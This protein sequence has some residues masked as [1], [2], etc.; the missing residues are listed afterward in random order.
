MSRNYKIVGFDWLERTQLKPHP[1]AQ[2]P[3]SPDD[4]LA[5]KE[6]IEDGGLI[7]PLLVLDKADKTDGLFEVVDGCN[8]LDDLKPGTKIPCVLIQCDNVR[9]VALTCLGTG[10]KRST[11]QRI[12]AY[13]EMHKREVVK[14]A[15]LGAQKAAGNPS[16]L[17]RDSAQISGVFANFTSE[18]ISQTLSVSQKDVLLAIDLLMCLEKKCTAPQRVGSL[19]TPARE[20]DLKDQ[21]D[22]VY[23]DCLKITHA[24]VMAGST[25]IRRWKAAQ[26][27]KST[28]A[29][30]RTEIDYAD[31]FREGL[32]HLRTASKHWKDITFKDRQALVELASKIGEV[33][34]PDVK[35]VL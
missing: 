11:G 20:L 8:R 33:L 22:K 5:L 18:A 9:E 34:P 32:N 7:Q 19:V 35:E 29:D 17:S 21:A 12:M 14:A 6:S 10:R 30:G 3:M 26:A 25:P 16:A 13:L 1:E 27:G 28:Q 2:L 15:E 24:N 31:L 4:Q 23:F